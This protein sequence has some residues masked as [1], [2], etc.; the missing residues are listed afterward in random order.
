M[1]NGRTVK[2]VPE[3]ERHMEKHVTF[4]EYVREILKTATY[5][6]GEDSDCVIGLAE[7]L[8]GC[9]TQGDTFEEAREL[10]IDAIELWVLLAV[11]DG[12][13][14]P[15]LLEFQQSL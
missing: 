2:R 11:K 9:M 7:V 15:V 3:G 13:D 8:P 6:P 5:K 10:L 12:D 4:R 14:L 1:V